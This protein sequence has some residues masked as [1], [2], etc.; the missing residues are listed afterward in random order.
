MFLSLLCA[1]TVAFVGCKPEP[2]EPELPKGPESV[3]LGL[4]VQWATCNVGA[5]NPQDYGNCYAWGEVETKEE[6]V[7][8]NYKYGTG[9]KHSL[10]SKLTK[11]CTKEEF[12]K[13]G[14]TDDKL[15]LDPED[16]AAHVNWGGTWRMPTE[17]EWLE[18]IEQCAWTLETR[19]NTIGYR[20]TAK[21]GNSIFLPAAGYR[22]YVKT[23]EDGTQDNLNNV[24][25]TGN[26]WTSSLAE[27]GPYG[28]GYVFFDLK[29]RIQRRGG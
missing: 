4:S 11:Y 21:N 24:D 18:L 2:N 7:P 13:D 14:F 5:E 26:Y 22:D 6:Y 8:Q 23:H 3:D 17:S 1:A 27:E 28:A 29:D 10:E 20:V 16:D 9:G 19:S 12:G 15:T 25:K